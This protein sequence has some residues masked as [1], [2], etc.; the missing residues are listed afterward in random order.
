MRH[1]VKIFY[2][3]KHFSGQLIILLCF[4]LFQVL[5]NFF[6]LIERVQSGSS[7]G[8]WRG[9]WEVEGSSEREKDPWAWTTMWGLQG[10][11]VE[12]EEGV[13]EINGNGKNTIKKKK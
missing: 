13:R 7:G 1:I 3:S 12:V 10:W 8:R 4:N 9:V 6:R 11:G 2:E 5:L